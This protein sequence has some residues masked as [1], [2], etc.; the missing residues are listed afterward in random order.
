MTLLL[1]TA[2]PQTDWRYPFLLYYNQLYGALL[3]TYV[4]FRLDRQSWTRQDT[5]LERGLSAWRTR[6]LAFSSA[7]MHMTALALFICA[8]GAAGGYFHMP[9]SGR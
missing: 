9:L 3:K 4:L 5:R 7:W 6:A 8:I 2:R 1:L